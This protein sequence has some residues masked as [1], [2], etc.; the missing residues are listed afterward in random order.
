MAIDKSRYPKNWKQIR[1]AILARAGNCCEECGIANGAPIPRTTSTQGSMFP[2]PPPATDLFGDPLQRV[3]RVVLTIAHLDHTP[4]NC[5]PENLKAL[6][7]RCHLAY[8][9][10]YHVEESHK[11]REAKK[12]VK[13][14]SNLFKELK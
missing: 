1:K 7:Q 2:P 4:E 3:S 6:C 10:D 13:P 5:G 14:Q 9:L 12:P 8:D 11:T